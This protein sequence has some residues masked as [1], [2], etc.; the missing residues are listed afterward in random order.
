MQRDNVR[1]IASM[2][3]LQTIVTHD[4][5]DE[6]HR[7]A[8]IP[9][10]YQNTLFSFPDHESFR[11]AMSHVLDQP[12]YSR[13]NN[14]TVEGLER[15]LAM[16]E[17]GEKARCFASGMAAMTAA[18]LSVVRSGDHIVCVDHC[19]VQDFLRNYLPRFGIETTF[20][21]GRSTDAVRKAFRANTKL[22]YLES[23]SSMVMHVQDIAACASLAKAFGARTIIDNTWAT[24]CFQ[25]PIALGVDLVAHSLTKYIGGHSDMMG[26]VVIGSAELVDP[27]SHN[28]YMSLGGL[29]S[30]AAASLAMR[31]LRTLPLRME[32]LAHNG[33]AVASYLENLPF[34]D[35]VNHPGLASF[36]QREVAAK[37]M[38]GYGSLFSFETRLP[39]ELVVR[40]GDRLRY[41]RI[42]VSWGGYES[43]VIVTIPSEE[44][45]L[46]GVVLVR[47]YVG[48]E[49]PGALIDDIAQAFAFVGLPTNQMSNGNEI[50][51]ECLEK[52]LER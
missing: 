41:F 21:D 47:M 36:P 34:I 42:G 25:N 14:P 45:R 5:H 22:L 38:S 52:R 12:V 2:A 15:T 11:G 43:L 27:I 33:L 9:P 19:Y 20:V 13:G 4:P 16:L 26:G 18:I 44:Q 10:I 23:P 31:G 30:P 29:L 7:G 35:R 32:R 6:R 8:V 1:P 50:G 28:E 3:K 24:P 37:Q 40:W 51:G 49:N 39:E 17:G 48:L 46:E